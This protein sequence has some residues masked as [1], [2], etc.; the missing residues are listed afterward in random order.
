METKELLEQFEEEID[1]LCDI[2]SLAE[3]RYLAAIASNDYVTAS[4]YQ[5]DVMVLQYHREFIPRV[6]DAIAHDSLDA[7]MSGLMNY[8]MYLSLVSDRPRAYEL[9]KLD[10]AREYWKLVNKVLKARDK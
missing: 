3:K 2:D 5:H 1:R 6:K 9:A 10:A 7:F 4:E 8:I